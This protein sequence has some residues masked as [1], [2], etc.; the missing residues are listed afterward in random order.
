MPAI[1]PYTSTYALTNA[2]LS[3]GLEIADKGIVRAARENPALA[4]GLNTYRGK[5]THNGVATAFGLNL[6]P[7]AEVFSA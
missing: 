1:V 3:Y 7:L 5:V 6:L 2:T 4:K